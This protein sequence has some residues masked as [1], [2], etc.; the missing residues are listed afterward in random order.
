MINLVSSMNWL[1][2]KTR[3]VIIHLYLDTANC[4][5]TGLWASCS[6][7]EGLATYHLQNHVHWDTKIDG[8]HHFQRIW[9]LSLWW[10]KPNLKKPENGRLGFRRLTDLCFGATLVQQRITIFGSFFQGID[11]STLATHKKFL[12]NKILMIS[13]THEL[14]KMKCTNWETI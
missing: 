1:Y 8:G 11:G 3:L 4:T 9:N 2:R 12:K 6:L 10:C 7:V 5:P 13:L 14:D